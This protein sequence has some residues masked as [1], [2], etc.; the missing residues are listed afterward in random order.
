MT[1]LRQLA[2]FFILLVSTVA[3]APAVRPNILL[4]VS[5]D[6]GYA[7]AGFQGAK[8]LATPHLD[9]LAASGVRFTNGYVTHP[10]CSPT[11]AALMTG[12]YQQR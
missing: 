11:R 3:A 1:S 12:R 7:D 5:D 8:D 6:Q 9:R 10:F 4:I 2:P